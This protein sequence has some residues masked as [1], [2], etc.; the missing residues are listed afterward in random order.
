MEEDTIQIDI[1]IDYFKNLNLLNKKKNIL[2]I[3]SLLFT[4]TLCVMTV[5][6]RYPF[7][8]IFTILSVILSLFTITAVLLKSKGLIDYSYN[9]CLIHMI[10]YFFI[11][12]FGLIVNI[13]LFFTGYSYAS[14]ILFAIIYSILLIVNVIVI[15]K[16]RLKFKEIVKMDNQYPNEIYK[17]YKI[18]KVATIDY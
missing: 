12:I 17:T 6:C 5:I 9:A 2:F 14:S 7:E 11:L 16:G 1:N 10:S 13:R 15:F 4:Y 8:F 18:E 3:N